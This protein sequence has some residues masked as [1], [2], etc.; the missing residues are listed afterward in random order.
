MSVVLFVLRISSADY[1]P[2]LL[3]VN[4]PFKKG[5]VQS[6]TVYL[7][8]SVTVS[9]PDCKQPSM[10]RDL[11]MVKSGSGSGSGS[12]PLEGQFRLSCGVTESCDSGAWQSD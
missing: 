12:G 9:H 4:V 3:I 6:Q 2:C 10:V 7:T 1:L 5:T 8:L 11:D